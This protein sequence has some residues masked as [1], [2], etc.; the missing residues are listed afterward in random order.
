MK[1]YPDLQ[2][3]TLVDVIELL[4]YVNKERTNDIKDFDNLTNV[5][6][7][8]RKVG[9][10]PTGA[11]DISSS[12]RVGDFNYDANYIYICINNAGAA[13][14]RRATLASW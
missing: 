11:A 9:K 14:W 4:R 10:I 3:R 1:D 13:Q 6:I 2:P 5:F 8:G 7:S 12:D